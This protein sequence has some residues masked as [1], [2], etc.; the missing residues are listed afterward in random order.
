MVPGLPYHVTQRGN[1]RQ[2][3]FFGIEDYAFYG[4]CLTV[5]RQVAGVEVWARCLMPHHM[6]RILVPPNPDGLRRALAPT[7]GAMPAM[8]MRVRSG[9]GIFGEGAMAR[10]PWMRRISCTRCAMS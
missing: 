4:D 2:C 1:G 7:I 6:H 8:S 9:R 5:H 10:L 3:T